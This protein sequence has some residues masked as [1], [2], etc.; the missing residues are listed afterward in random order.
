MHFDLTDLRLFAAVL[1]EGSITAGASREAIS[2]PSASA[3]MKGMEEELGTALLER[4]RRGV[5]PTPAGS[6]LFHH[7]QLVLAQ[8]E[9]VV[10]GTAIRGLSSCSSGESPGVGGL[11]CVDL[12][13]V[14]EFVLASRRGFIGGLVTVPWRDC[15]TVG[16]LAWSWFSSWFRSYLMET[17]TN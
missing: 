2:L 5:R 7:A 10:N 9:A 15:G 16:G 14:Q 3:R 1:E 17:V 12:P 4:H 11:Y 8:M 6:T 13:L